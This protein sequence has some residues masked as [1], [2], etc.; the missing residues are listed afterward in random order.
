MTTES[1]GRPVTLSPE[2]LDELDVVARDLAE[3]CRKTPAAMWRSRK[4]AESVPVLTAELRDLRW[5]VQ[6]ALEH[7]GYHDEDAVGR[8]LRGGR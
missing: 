1:D 4:L 7:L 3:R 5:R 6:E 2:A 8:V